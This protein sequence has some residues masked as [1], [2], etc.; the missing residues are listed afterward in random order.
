MT[1]VLLYKKK[2]ILMYMYVHN[3]RAPL[4]G[5]RAPCASRLRHNVTSNVDDI[6]RRRRDDLGDSA[7]T[8]TP[9]VSFQRATRYFHL[10]FLL[11]LSLVL[12]LATFM[13]IYMYICK[14]IYMYKDTKS[15]VYV[16]LRDE[17]KETSN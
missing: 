11:P 17:I 16:A 8:S 14:C 5:K 7:R 13:Y 6:R 12:A 1:Y 9:P 2:N 15:L 3:R 10:V 4:D